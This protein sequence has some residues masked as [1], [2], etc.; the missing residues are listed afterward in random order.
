MSGS[1]AY[2]T[3]L[4]S[5]SLVVV[6]ISNPASP[7]IR[8]SVVSSSLLDGVRVQPGASRA[9][10]ASG[11]AHQARVRG[12]TASADAPWRSHSLA[13]LMCA[14]AHGVAVSGSY[15]Y[16]TALNSDSL[17]VVDISNPAS[18]VIRG[19]VISSSLL[20]GVR[21]R[22]GVS[23]AQMAS[24]AALARP[25]IMLASAAPPPADA[26]SHSHSLAALMCTQA[27]GVAVSGSYA[28]VTGYYSDSLVV[29]DISNPASPVIRGSV[30]SSS[31]LDGVRVRPGALCARMVSGAALASAPSIVLASAAP[32]PADALSRSHSLAITRCVHRQLA[33]P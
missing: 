5:D 8:G 27:D 16:V 14:Q 19:S 21:V 10:M 31:L 24:G 28:Y 17:V 18:P 15:A 20:N 29:V 30:V 9:R 1:Y 6:D 12:A 26:L 22:P 33:S 2:V 3:A 11:A 4:N 32:P 25:S 13:A 7:A 23:R